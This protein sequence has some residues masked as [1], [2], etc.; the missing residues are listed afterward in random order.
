[1]TP[2]VEQE[3]DFWK[4][5]FRGTG[6]GPGWKALVF[7]VHVPIHVVAAVLLG[8][9]CDK[10][11]SDVAV[12]ALLPLAG[13]L[14]GVAFAWATNVQAILQTKEWT[15]TISRSR[16]SVSDYVFEYLSAILVIMSTIG[17]W[18]LAALGIFDKLL[19][20][21][22]NPPFP[23]SYRI[24]A[25]VVYFLTSGSMHLCWKVVSAAQIKL[26]SALRLGELRGEFEGKRQEVLEK[27]HA[28]KAE[29][30]REEMLQRQREEAEAQEQKDRP[31]I[32]LGRG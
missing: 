24:I 25:G 32:Y 18:G 8:I 20:A 31:S 13:V 2:P 30:E 9:Y 7:D 17:I 23:V 4:W 12:T 19:P 21:G 29:K 11:L 15:S 10:K 16:Y 6:A 5:F 14:V 3:A 28:A 1:M 27:L 26:V 22:P